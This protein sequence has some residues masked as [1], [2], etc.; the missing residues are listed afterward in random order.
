M[1]PDA[2]D[3][4]IGRAYKTTEAEPESGFVTVTIRGHGLVRDAVGSGVV[5]RLWY[6]VKRGGKNEK[7]PRV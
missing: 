3:R 4:T 6:A 2:E 5:G 1:G 7:S